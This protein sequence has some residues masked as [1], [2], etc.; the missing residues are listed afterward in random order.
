MKEHPETF[1]AARR[2]PRPASVQLPGA[3]PLGLV[4]S[5]C[6]NPL[7]AWLPTNRFVNGEELAAC[8]PRTEKRWGQGD[9]SLL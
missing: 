4:F 8:V 5:I 1:G 6:S 3:A 9:L 7:F 2:C